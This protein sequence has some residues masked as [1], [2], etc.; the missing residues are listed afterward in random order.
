MDE[1]RERMWDGGERRAQ[2]R[3]EPRGEIPVLFEHPRLPGLGAGQI[4]DISRGGACIVAPPTTMTPLRW[5]EPLTLSIS[6]LLDPENPTVITIDALVLEIRST[7]ESYRIRCRFVHSLTEP[8]LEVL[9]GF[10]VVAA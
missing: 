5:G 8:M 9:A 6:D 10:E 2:G 7:S 3:V 1:K 4:I